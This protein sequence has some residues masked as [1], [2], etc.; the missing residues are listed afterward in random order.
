MQTGVDKIPESFIKSKIMTYSLDA[1]IRFAEARGVEY[2]SDA[3]REE[4][5]DLILN[6]H[7]DLAYELYDATELRRSLSEKLLLEN[8]PQ[9]AQTDREKAL[10]S[11][12]AERKTQALEDA[13]LLMSQERAKTFRRYLLKRGSLEKDPSVLLDPGSAE[14]DELRSM[15]EMRLT[16]PGKQATLERV[17]QRRDSYLFFIKY[18][19]KIKT[20]EE[21]EGRHWDTLVRRVIAVLHEPTSSLE[22]G[23]P[24]PRREEA[25]V[26]AVSAYLTGREDAFEPW[27]ISS[28]R[29][30]ASISDPEWQ[31]EA[32][33]S[34]PVGV[35]YVDFVNVNLEGRPQKMSL[36]GEDVLLTLSSL[37]RAGLDLS[38]IGQIHK[39]RFD[40]KGKKTDL[41]PQEG[42]FLFLAYADEAERMSFYE[43]ISAMGWG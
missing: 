23:T 18:V 36:L 34:G 21:M 9:G 22:I 10:L 2:P 13:Q 43:W 12:L 16:L 6:Q 41:F 3:S 38:K 27:D 1:L 15:I 25:A 26:A 20:A 32:A 8:A 40:F 14:F 35:T 33:G 24:N 4:F 39:V 42:K 7:R 19:D 31:S 11:L 37:R 28:E 29:L 30:L 5:V 17:L